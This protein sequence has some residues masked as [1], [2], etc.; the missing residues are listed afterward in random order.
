MPK[1]FICQAQDLNSASFCRQQIDSSETSFQV[2]LRKQIS[3]LSTAVYLFVF[4][5]QRFC[6]WNFCGMVYSPHACASFCESLHEKCG[7]QAFLKTCSRNHHEGTEIHGNSAAD[8]W[9][10]VPLPVGHRYEFCRECF[11]SSGLPFLFSW[12]FLSQP[13]I[14]T[15][16]HCSCNAVQND[17]Q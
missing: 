9:R 12:V 2:R 7:N 15:L 8:F 13:N 6:T 11:W 14:F 16:A 4:L 5:W 1:L 17:F 3:C 10:I